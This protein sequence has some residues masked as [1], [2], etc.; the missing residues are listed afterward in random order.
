MSLLTDTLPQKVCIDNVIFDINTDFR[1]SILFEELILNEDI[2]SIETRN[3]VLNMY[4]PVV[5]ENEDNALNAIMWLY[6]CG[7]PEEERAF[8]NKTHENNKSISDIYSFKYDDELIY[9][10]FLDQYRIDLIDIP[11]LHWW[12]FKAMFKSLKSDNKIVE[13][14]GYRNMDL[15]SIKDNNQKDFYKRMQN[16]YKLPETINKDE[17]EKQKAIEDALLNGGDL[18]LI[19]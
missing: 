10:A 12:K 2:N 8:Q 9:S 3:K 7:R 14:M 13:I 6:S 18:S 15:N 4:F 1:T 19:L 5:P 11:Y 17:L 16:I